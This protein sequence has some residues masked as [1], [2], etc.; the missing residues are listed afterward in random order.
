MAAALSP[1]LH[2]AIEQ[3]PLSPSPTSSN[4]RQ[5]PG[6]QS[7]H[8]TGKG[9]E[10]QYD[11]ERDRADRAHSVWGDIEDET[12]FSTYQKY[13]LAYQDHYPYIPPIKNILRNNGDER[14]FCSIREI[15]VPDQIR[16]QRFLSVLKAD[17]LQ[18][19]SHVLITLEQPRPAVSVHV[20]F[21]E[22]THD[23]PTEALTDALGLGLHLDPRFFA[24]LAYVQNYKS[25]KSLIGWPFGPTQILLGGMVAIISRYYKPSVEFTPQVVLIVSNRSCMVQFTNILEGLNRDCTGK[26]PFREA[27]SEPASQLN[28]SLIEGW[29]RAA[30]E[31]LL[32]RISNLRRSED[33]ITGNPAFDSLLPLLQLETIMIRKYYS[34]ARSMYKRLRSGMGGTEALYE[35][36]AQTRF[37]LRRFIEQSDE[38]RMAFAQFIRT[39]DYD[40]DWLDQKPYVDIE[41]DCH[42][43]SLVARTLETEI[44]NYLQSRAAEVALEESKKSIELSNHQISEGKRGK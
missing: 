4:H 33:D 29:W 21:L 17:E 2:D 1:R 41:N 34:H 19:G 44:G 6:Y 42:G 12:S 40:G 7:L 22:I 15:I 20:A 32:E 37:D 38:R 43:A 18:F 3:S 24:S 27:A 36:C 25:N 35:E 13:L 30:Y 11:A 31:H 8:A 26:A 16:C 14:A 23:H 5:P 10:V 28:G 9:A 39:Q